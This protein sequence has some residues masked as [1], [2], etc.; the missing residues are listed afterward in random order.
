MK[1]VIFEEALKDAKGHWP[2][3]IKTLKQ[4]FEAM[5]DQVTVLGHKD[6]SQSLCNDLP[7]IPLFRKSIWDGNISRFD[8]LMHSWHYSQ[9][10]R[11]Y[12][13]NEQTPDIILCPTMR[14]PQLLGWSFL[15]K[16][17]AS[18]SNT[19]IILLFVQGPGLWNPD[20]HKAEIPSSKANKMARWAIGRLSKWVKAGKVILATE[21]QKMAQEWSDFT[22]VPFTT[23]PHP[24]EDITPKPISKQ[25]H[26]SLT[27]CCPGF[28][29]HEKGTDLLQAAIRKIS[30]TH[31]APS[32]KF[33]LQW[34]DPFFMPDGGKEEPDSDLI[35]S[36]H[37]EVIDRVIDTEEYNQLLNNSHAV[38]MPYRLQ[39]YY[40]R[41][42]RVAIE[43]SLKGLP[44][45]FTAESWLEDHTQQ[46]GAG[47][48]FEDNNVDSLT[49]ALI[50]L[51]KNYEEL[52]QQ[53]RTRIA[54]SKAFYST[55]EFRSIML[56]TQ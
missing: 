2:S 46:F 43:A 38:V 28:A 47:V 35:Q 7:L 13:K 42:S 40:A 3:Y 4:G 45:V 32:L 55:Q 12:I 53:A 1:I 16:S 34:L 14:L 27:I 48:P 17:V 21:T 37:L 20:T 5:G 23:F 50:Q 19:R 39:S 11:R 49:D 22:G 36:G 29:R 26:D 25:A 30:H 8:K 51:A 41:V 10:V 6:A 33:V 31:N 18:S 54:A 9:D 24:V 44:I 56:A 15:A 52:S